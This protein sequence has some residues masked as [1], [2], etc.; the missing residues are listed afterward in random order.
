MFVPTKA[1]VKLT[2]G[3]TVYAQAIAIILSSF[4]NF[5]IIY[6]VGPVYYFPGHPSSTISLG[7]LKFYV[8]FKNITSETLEPCDFL[9]PR[10]RSW[11]SP[12]QN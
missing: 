6:L 1:T 8:D 12:Y 4:N 7:A 11:I 3:K 9:D 2:N 5:T 10:G